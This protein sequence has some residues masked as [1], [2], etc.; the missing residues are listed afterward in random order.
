MQ[1]RPVYY[2]NIALAQ[3]LYPEVLAYLQDFEKFN[4]DNSLTEQQFKNAYQDLEKLL[5]DLTQKD[6]SNYQLWEWWECEGVGV[7]AF[8]IAL[9]NPTI[10]QF[11]KD[12]L[13]DIVCII[14]NYT[15]PCQNE[16]EDLFCSHIIDNY[17]HQLLA[18]NFPKS[19]DYDYF[20]RHCIGGKL[21]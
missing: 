9:P 14:K 16:F 7:L 18:L 10:Y 6:M 8:E 12:E 15:Y 2:P 3:N 21:C 4:D 1:H 20:L 19:Y 11:N 13:R 17:F 5:Q